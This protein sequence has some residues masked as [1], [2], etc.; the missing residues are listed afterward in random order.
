[1]PASVLLLLLV[2][3]RHGPILIMRRLLPGR[4]RGRVLCSIARPLTQR[5]LVLMGRG[6]LGV[7]FVRVVLALRLVE[8]WSVL[9]RS[10]WW[11]RRLLLKRLVTPACLLSS[12]STSRPER[13]GGSK[14]IFLWLRIDLIL[15]VFHS[16]SCSVVLRWRRWG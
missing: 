16:P 14:S 15:V 4:G 7:L 12:L 3:G 2:Q 1:M 10:R 9:G 13:Q 11:S 6:T 8:W 5:R